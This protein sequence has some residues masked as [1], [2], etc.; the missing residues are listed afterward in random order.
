VRTAS[1]QPPALG[2]SLRSTQIESTGK[3]LSER[4]GRPRPEAGWRA[5]SLIRLI[6]V[7]LAGVAWSCAPDSLP[8]FPPGVLT[9][10]YIS[11]GPLGCESDSL[12]SVITDTAFIVGSGQ[13]P[14]AVPA[15]DGST[16]VAFRGRG[17]H[18]SLDGRID[19]GI[20][21]STNHLLERLSPPE[22]DSPLDDR[23]P[24]L[25]ALSP[26]QWVLIY[27]EL[28]PGGPG[29]TFDIRRAQFRLRL[30]VTP[31]GGR[32]W[33]APRIP[34]YDGVDTL[35]SVPY[36]KIRRLGDGT[37]LATFYASRD[38]MSNYE[39]WRPVMISSHDDGASWAVQGVLPSPNSETAVIQV[40]GDTI[41][42]AMRSTSDS[43]QLTISPNL[44]R[45]WTAPVAVTRVHQVP[46]DLAVLPNGELLLVYGNRAAPLKGIG[47]RRVNRVRLALGASPPGVVATVSTAGTDFGY[48]SVARVRA[49]GRV[50][51]VYYV[52]GP[53]VPGTTQLHLASFCPS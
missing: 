28:N 35:L 26:S 48:P 5:R 19:F 13:F 44:G 21:D 4:S 40:A 11:A 41:V 30:S 24:E 18:V 2:S 23:G 20:L 31:D 37:L 22:L 16:V 12:S 42:A 47:Y 52:S 25:I 1:G 50:T 38:S 43:I 8:L 15:G 45:N 7:G 49:D 9:T 32:T 27:S 3:G 36:G 33:S 17:T 29:G 34:L 46:G 14:V 51:L 39:S 10:A 53:D 6:A